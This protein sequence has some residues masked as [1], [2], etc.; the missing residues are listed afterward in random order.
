MT[1]RLT[2]PQARR[3]VIASLGLARP[4]PT[5]RV[6]ARHLRRVYDDIGVIQI[7]PINVLAR[8][9]HQVAMSR[10]G[11]Y[12][13]TAL[14]RYIWRSGEVWE[15]W[16]HVDATSTVDTW[17]L[18]AH[19]R[20]NT[21]PWR[22]WRGMDEAT[23]AYIDGVLAQI[24]ERGELAARD[25]ADPGPRIATWGNRT[26]G[27]AVLDFLHHRGQLA[28]SWRD[29]RMTAF[30]DLAERVIPQAWRD[31]D[32]P[33]EDEA[34][35]LLLRRAVRAQ[36]LG[37]PADLADH[38]RQHVPTARTHL[39]DLAAAGEIEL[40]E[41]DGWRGPVYADPDL[42]V[43]RRVHAHALV[44]PFD[45]L[46]WNRKRL[47]RLWGLDYTIEVYVPKAERRFGYYALPF[48]LGEEIVALVDLKHERKA[49]RLLVQ[50]LTEL[51]PF[52]RGELDEEL[53]AWASWLGAEP[54]A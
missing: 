5:G 39:R 14:D 13:R 4:R 28:I 32:V 54:P 51:H 22:G 38:F 8:S 40:I 1:R 45:P 52:D 24:A 29:D 21:M 50:Q 9:H 33:E 31:A 36:G 48:L 46:I 15:G 44:N 42:V 10:L 23:T 20:A 49:N 19:R 12:D 34:E 25:L 17:P 41:V 27:R 53:I 3:A 6:D 47:Q 30:F 16:I 35:R 37:T 7:D 11:P 26:L 18:L 2:V 43:P